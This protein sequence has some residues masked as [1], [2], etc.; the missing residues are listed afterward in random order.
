MWRDMNECVCRCGRKR[1]SEKPENVD[2]DVDV[3]ENRV[4]EKPENMNVD[5]CRGTEKNM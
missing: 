4:N 1:G 5:V 2:V 3:G